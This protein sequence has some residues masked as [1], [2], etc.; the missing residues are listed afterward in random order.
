VADPTGR[1]GQ[2]TLLVE[3]SDS[4]GADTIESLSVTQEFNF[5]HPDHADEVIE[6]TGLVP[7][8]VEDIGPGMTAA[9]FDDPRFDFIFKADKQIAEYI[10]TN[11]LSPIEITQI[12]AGIFE[13]SFSSE[14]PGRFP[15]HLT[16]TDTDGNT[17]TSRVP[18]EVYWRENPWERRGVAIDTLWDGSSNRPNLALLPAA[19]DVIGALNANT[20]MLTVIG[21]MESADST[22]VVHCYDQ[23]TAMQWCATPTAAEIGRFIDRAHD[24]G[25]QVL[26]WPI[27]IADAEDQLE[28]WQLQLSDWDTF[29]ESYSSWILEYAETAEVHGAEAAFVTGGG[30]RLLSEHQDDFARLIASMREIYTGEIIATDFW[31][32][33]GPFPSDFSDAYPTF[34]GDLDVIGHPI[35]YPAAEVVDPSPW[36]M[37]EYLGVGTLEGIARPLWPTFGKPLLFTELG[38]WN[39]DGSAMG[40]STTWTRVTNPQKDNQEQLDY[41][42]AG[43]KSVVETPGQQGV[44][45]WAQRIT[46]ELLDLDWFPEDAPVRELVRIWFA[47]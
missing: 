22:E 8:S 15:L 30:G 20:V 42:E 2:V 33:E 23:P 45:I 46:D 36:E 34:F 26:L 7:A 3:V 1:T 27:L 31:S 24:G 47:D 37:H 38:T 41:T 9:R 4:D 29:F 16:A 43:L 12:T 6:R 13:V 39:I 25:L 5:Q 17:T 35:F 10:S 18:V 32:W 19:V 21:T 40:P 14:W 11:P 44:I 28:L